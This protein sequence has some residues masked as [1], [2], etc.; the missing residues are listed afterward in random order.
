M[1]DLNLVRFKNATLASRLTSFLKSKPTKTSYLV[2]IALASIACVAVGVLGLSGS[3]ISLGLTIG[4]LVSLALMGT[5]LGGVFIKHA[6]L[7]SSCP[8]LTPEAVEALSYAKEQARIKEEIFDLGEEET[9]ATG[10]LWGRLP[11]P[12]GGIRPS[13]LNPAISQIYAL[14]IEKGSKLMNLLDM[15][16]KGKHDSPSTPDTMEKFNKLATEYLQL[17]FAVSYLG[18]L[19]LPLYLAKNPSVGSHLEILTRRELSY[20]I[21]FY[22]MSAAYS[23]LRR[24]H[25]RSSDYSKHLT[26]EMVK[27]RERM[28][29]QEGLEGGWRNLY[30]CFCEQAQWYI[31]SKKKAKA[32]EP[33]LINHS[34]PDLGPIYKFRGN[35]VI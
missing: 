20:Y 32:L 28:F 1:V 18:L 22:K 8:P 13:P 11:E 30:N 19:D 34:T 33:S 27:N 5:L 14:Q 16:D 17:S 12:I 26:E 29:Y 6:V 10:L 21:T 25:L 24:L 23:F 31:G 2:A 3:A 7:T 35:I 4:G 15:T 9:P